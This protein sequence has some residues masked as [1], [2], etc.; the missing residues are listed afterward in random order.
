M[1]GLTTT[2]TYWINFSMKFKVTVIEA[3]RGW[4]QKID[5]VR[6]FNDAN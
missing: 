4:G 2:K 1:V 5:E 3:E 6:Y